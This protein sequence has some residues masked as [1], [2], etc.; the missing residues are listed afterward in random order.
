MKIMATKIPIGVNATLMP[1]SASGAP[2]QPFCANSD[3]SATPATAV[4]SANGIST[5]A[6][7]NRRPGKRYRTSAQTMIIP[8]TRLTNAAAKARPNEIFSALRVRRLERMPQN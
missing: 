8:I 6:S 3:V 4:G 7:N 5:M 2:S 1:S